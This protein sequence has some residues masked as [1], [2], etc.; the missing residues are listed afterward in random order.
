[1]DRKKLVHI[2][3]AGLLL[4]ATACAESYTKNGYIN[5]YESWV[6]NLQQEY[7]DYEDADWPQAEKE[8]KRFSET[9]FNRFKDD[10]TPEERQKIDYLTG[11]YYALVLKYNAK[12][13]KEEFKSIMNKAKG[14]FDELEK[15]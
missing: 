13:I 8:F 7:M 14:M 10:I 15:E 6:N 4:C 9:E 11:Q 5:D 3:V 1:M 2:L 12:Q